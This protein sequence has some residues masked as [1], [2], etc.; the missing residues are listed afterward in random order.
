MG[1][2]KVDAS[3]WDEIVAHYSNL[4][5]PTPADRRVMKFILDKEARRQA[6]EDFREDQAR[7]A[8]IR[9]LPTSSGR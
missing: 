5:N 7:Y 8:R 3:I 9:D 6:R 2:V 4:Q 1:S